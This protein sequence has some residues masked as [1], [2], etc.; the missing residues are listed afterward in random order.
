MNNSKLERHSYLCKFP[1]AHWRF[2]QE[3][4]FN[5]GL[6]VA[7]YINQLVYDERMRCLYGNG[8]LFSALEEKEESISAGSNYKDD[9]LDD[10]FFDKKV[11]DI[12]KSKDEGRGV[13]REID[14][15]KKTFSVHFFEDDFISED[16]CTWFYFKDYNHDNFLT[17]WYEK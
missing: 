4:A 5:K 6:T 16:A 1:L 14:F 11:G 8:G 10:D 12:V 13:I 15:N 7:A 9:D 2:L 3:N 17:N